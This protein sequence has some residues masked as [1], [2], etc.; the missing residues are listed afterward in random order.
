MLTTNYLINEYGFKRRSKNK[1]KLL[2]NENYKITLKQSDKYS[3][4]FVDINTSDE[5]HNDGDIV[6]KFSIIDVENMSK[7][8]HIGLSEQNL[9]QGNFKESYK[10]NNQNDNFFISKE[11]AKKLLEAQFNR[12]ICNALM[13]SSSIPNYNY[14][15]KETKYEFRKSNNIEILTL[16][17]NYK[18]RYGKHDFW[19]TYDIYEF[20]KDKFPINRRINAFIPVDL[21]ISKFLK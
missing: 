7:I 2:V 4:V 11:K 9:K 13:C 12:S 1:E 8:F 19:M 15:I 16:C 14:Y 17:Y 21:L 6:S 20:Q 18:D 3:N 5:Y 10:E